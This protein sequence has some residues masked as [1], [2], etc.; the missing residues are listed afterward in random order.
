MTVHDD[1]R[2]R[3][4]KV[5]DPELGVSIVDLGMVGEVAVDDA[6]HATVNVLLTTTGCPLR[7]QIERDVRE[8]ALTIDGLTSVRVAMQVMDA[9]ARSALMRRARTFAQEHPPSTSIPPGAPVLMIASGKGGVGKSS[10]TA[11]LAV[12]MAQSGLRVGVLDADIWGFSLS[13]LLGITGEVRTRDAKMLP[14]ERVV[15]AGSVHVL[16][17]GLLADEDQ[18]LLWRGLIVQKAVAQFIEDADWSGIDYLLIDTPPGT[19]DI[20]MTLARIVPRMGQLVVTTP[21]LAAQ[22]VAARAADFARKSNIRV[23]GV[24]EN[25][26]G[27]RCSCGKRHHLFGEGGGRR[28]AEEL[29]VALLAEIE[30]RAEIALGGDLGEPAVLDEPKDGPFHLLAR[31]IVSD[32]APPVGAPG[33]SARLLEALDRAVEPLAQSS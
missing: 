6:G 31:R 33:C 11:N 16:S 30:L 27:L 8:A 32:V 20:A 2:E 25:M 4:A 28:L 23:L 1:I 7:T 19:G 12:A 29:D 9:E 17:M 22:R 18:A 26:S 3:L 13:R 10:I 14:L 24:I 15:G 21:N 5:L